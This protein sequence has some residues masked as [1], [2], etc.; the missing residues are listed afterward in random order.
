MRFQIFKDLT[1]MPDW[2]VFYFLGEIVKGCNVSKGMK[3]KGGSGCFT[4]NAKVAGMDRI[5]NTIEEPCRF[6][7][8]YVRASHMVTNQ[9]ICNN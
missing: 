8:S 5:R 4:C 2:S 7:S 3:I 6:A 9:S 1:Y